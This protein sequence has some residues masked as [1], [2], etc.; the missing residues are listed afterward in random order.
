MDSRVLLWSPGGGVLPSAPLVF[1]AR[2]PSYN[3]SGSGFRNTPGPWSS[4]GIMGTCQ[5]LSGSGSTR[6]K[7]EAGWRRVSS[8]PRRTRTGIRKTR[9]R[10][11][12]EGAGGGAAVEKVLSHPPPSG[13][14]LPPAQHSPF[15]HCACLPFQEVVMSLR[16]QIWLRLTHLHSRGPHGP[17]HLLEAA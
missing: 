4:H 6:R 16:F 3:Q 13:P 8:L 15:C 14:L 11:L 9:G 10:G 5:S 7:S 1:C 2:C 12:A 17:P